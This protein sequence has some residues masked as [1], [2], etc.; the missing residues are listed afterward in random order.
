MLNAW[1]LSGMLIWEL[2]GRLGAGEQLKGLGWSLGYI[3][4]K[5]A[6]GSL[7]LPPCLLPIHHD[8]VSS[9]TFSWCHEC[10]PHCE[11]TVK[12]TEDYRPKPVKPSL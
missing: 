9:P 6:C 1:C 5:T 7:S 11:L 10:L 8:G 2:V 12:R 4:F 3:H